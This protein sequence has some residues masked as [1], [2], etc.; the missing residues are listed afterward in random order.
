MHGRI[1]IQFRQSRSEEPLS[2]SIGLAHIIRH[3]RSQVCSLT[4]TVA[5]RFAPS[6]TPSGLSIWASPRC[7]DTSRLFDK[8][9]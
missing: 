4:A 8:N 2:R 7:V 9:I 1:A 5:L 3:D 6:T